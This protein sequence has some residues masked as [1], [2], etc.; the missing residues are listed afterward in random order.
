LSIVKSA[1]ASSSAKGHGAARVAVP[2]AGIA[3]APG[4]H[5][6]HP[7][8]LPALQ[9]L[10]AQVFSLF[11]T[12]PLALRAAQGGMSPAILMLSFA[13][14]QGALATGLARWRRLPSWWLGIQF[15]FP[16]AVV[17]ASAIALPR[18]IYLA[19]FL[20]LLLTYWSTFRTRVPLYNCGPVVWRQVGLL[21]PAGPLRFLDIGS[22]LGGIVLHLARSYPEGRFTGIEIAPLPWLVS[23]LR[24]AGRRMAAH[25]AGTGVAGACCF[26]RGDYGRQDLS[27]YDVVFAYLS[28]VAMPA[29]WE[30]ARE[31]MLPDALL[32]SLEFAIPGVVPDFCLACGDN[33]KPGKLLYGF[34]ISAA[35]STSCKTVPKTGHSSLKFSP[36]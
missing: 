36:S 30:K 11:L 16:L 22:G 24:A 34:R 3:I 4:D 2:N 33:D 18:W 28:P 14:L 27:Q 10:G 26:V 32:L 6:P 23:W 25:R 1:P 13:L 12:I 8:R 21:L 29:L 31:E 20:L 35:P 17:G 7:A 19:A 5:G 9:A 15:A